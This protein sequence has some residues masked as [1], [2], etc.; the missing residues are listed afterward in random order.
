L[1]RAQVF[2][3]QPRVQGAASGSSGF[4]GDRHLHLPNWQL[5]RYRGSAGSIG[6]RC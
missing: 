1:R 5:L 3:K 4:P 6:S 2:L